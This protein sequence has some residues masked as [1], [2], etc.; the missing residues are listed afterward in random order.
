MAVATMGGLIVATL[1]TL[2]S[3][4]AM[5]ADWF[6]VQRPVNGWVIQNSQRSAVSKQPA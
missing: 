3:L 1:L 4:P 2:I 6:R 5:Y